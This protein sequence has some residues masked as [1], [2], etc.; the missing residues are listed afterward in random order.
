MKQWQNTFERLYNDT[1]CSMTTKTTTSTTTTTQSLILLTSSYSCLVCFFYFNFL[2]SLIKYWCVCLG[3]C[4]SLLHYY[5][6]FSFIR[7]YIVKESA[8][9]KWLLSIFF[10]KQN[11]NI[12]TDSIKLNSS[13]LGLCCVWLRRTRGTLGWLINDQQSLCWCKCGN[14]WKLKCVYL[15]RS[16]RQTSNLSIIEYKKQM[17]IKKS[18]S[19]WIMNYNLNFNWSNFD[20]RSH[21]SIPFC[22]YF[23]RFF[24]F[25]AC[26][27]NSRFI[28]TS[29][30][31][32]TM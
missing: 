8:I 14:S 26:I 16:I 3:H 10:F 12:L 6:L 23:P 13:S 22:S 4:V 25:S 20:F 27:L 30:M 18:R 7:S 19:I 28:M 5:L 24:Q 21:S 2:R 29:R 9:T 1:A 31:H 17:M 15:W 32:C 11:N